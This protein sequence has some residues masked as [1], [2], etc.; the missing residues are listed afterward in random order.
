M[1]TTLTAALFVLFMGIAPVFW[2]S[3]SDFYEVRRVLFMI[4]MVIFI[5][6]S[7]GSAFITNI[8][9][10]VVLRC[11][12]SIGSSCGQSVG[13]G[14]LFNNV[15]P[16]F[17]PTFFFLN[18][19]IYSFSRYFNV[20]VIAD[21]YPVERRGAAFGKYFFGVFIGPLTGPIIGGALIMSSLT[22]R[23]TFWFCVALG[24]VIVICLF[25]LLPE[26]YRVNARFDTTLPTSDKDVKAN[27][28]NTNTDSMDGDSRSET[29][30]V[31]NEKG[32]DVAAPSSK[33]VLHTPMAK[34]R[35][36]IL[37]PFLMLRHPFVFLA[38][39]ISGITFGSMFAVETI[40][41]GLYGEHYGFS[42]W[43]TGLSYLGAGVGNM[44]ATFIVGMISDRLLLRARRLRGGKA[45]VE[46]RLTINLWP[47]GL[48]II[49]FGQLLF[50][51][52]IE[53]GLSVWAPI[54]GFGIHTFG[55]NQITTAT[56]AYLVDA[57]PGVGASATAA[58]N[59]VRMVIACVLTLVANPMVQALGPGWT[60][61]LLAALSWVSMALMFVLKFRGEALR[62]WSG[63]A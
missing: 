33:P 20:G 24:A 7:L 63:F 8:W 41:P 53:S 13:A 17:N 50:G 37:A 11:V 55:M 5:A 42:S 40:I 34:K 10:L 49:P 48:L 25:F 28:T 60:S 54:I 31:T 6:A 62:K 61:V 32:Q 44:T 39:L 2:A 22:W 35:F 30:S 43:Q 47:C 4:S 15:A 23:A 21:C 29:I 38:S 19:Q 45:L 51:W 27:E 59:L 16:L 12:Q 58:A 1:A 9:G 18:S 36:N 57:V 3:I 56:S 46:D 14:T 26:T 52:S